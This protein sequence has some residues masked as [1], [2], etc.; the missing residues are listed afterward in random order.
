VVAFFVR[1]SLSKGATQLIDE[2]KEKIRELR[3]KG[4][5]YKG[6]AVLLGLTRDCV[7]GFC[8]RNG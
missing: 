5:G 4:M 1:K 3:L 7:R 6:I 2:E 8:K